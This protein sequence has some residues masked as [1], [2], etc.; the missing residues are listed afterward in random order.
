MSINNWELWHAAREN[1]VDTQSLRHLEK[2]DLV[3]SG[4]ITGK[5][6]LAQLK[7]SGL[8]VKPLF[9]TEFDPEFNYRKLSDYARAKAIFFWLLLGVVTLN[10]VIIL[11]FTCL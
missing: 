2:C 10:L 11:L 3:K 1:K 5:D 8:E 7:K 4:T 6:L 9:M